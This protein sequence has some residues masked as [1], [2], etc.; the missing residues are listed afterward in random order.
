MTNLMKPGDVISFHQHHNA[1]EVI[2]LEEGGATVT[3]GKKR[4]VAGPR[5][6]VFIPRGEWVS[7]TNTTTHAIH[8][9]GFF[10]RQEFERYYRPSSVPEGE[11]V[12]PLSAHEL[13][14]LRTSAHATYWDTSKGPYPPG[15]AR[16]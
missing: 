4:A 13:A 15:V 16:P 14:R 7:F 1:E 12:T 8:V 5:S 9:Y 11:L 6:I 2:I 3:V 10:S